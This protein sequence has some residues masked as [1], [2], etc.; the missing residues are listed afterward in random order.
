MSIEKEEDKGGSLYVLLGA[1]QVALSL[2]EIVFNV[3]ECKKKYKIQTH[4]AK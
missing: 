1:L 3:L 4:F 2:L